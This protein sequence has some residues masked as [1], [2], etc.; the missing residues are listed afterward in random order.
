MIDRPGHERGFAVPAPRRADESEANRGPERSPEQ[1]VQAKFAEAKKAIEAIA[2][3]GIPKLTA[4]QPFEGD[5][6][7][8]RQ[9]RAEYDLAKEAIA[10]QFR[11]AEAAR[12]TAIKQAKQHG[13][14]TTALVQEFDQE[15]TKTNQAA[16]PSARGT[17]RLPARA[18]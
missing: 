8:A 3:V 4:A 1:V 11:N 7:G 10:S 2:D 6:R 9:R 16:R 13:I 12:T 15:V 18:R 14:D 5:R 17:A